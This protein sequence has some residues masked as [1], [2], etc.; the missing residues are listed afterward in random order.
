MHG[1]ISGNSLKI[2]VAFTW[3]FWHVKENWMNFPGLRYLNRD[4]YCCSCLILKQLQCQALFS[5][6]AL[7]FDMTI[8]SSILLMDLLIFRLIFKFSLLPFILIQKIIATLYDGFQWQN[9]EPSVK[10]IMWATLNTSNNC[11]AVTAILLLIR[12]NLLQFSDTI[13]L[14]SDIKETFMSGLK[15]FHTAFYMC[16]SLFLNCR[17]PR[18]FSNLA[19]YALHYNMCSQCG[20]NTGLNERWPPIYYVLFLKL[21][22]VSINWQ[23]QKNKNKNN[24][25]NNKITKSWSPR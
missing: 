22:Q 2:H 13:S 23:K 18:V 11:N 1:Q 25:K 3:E 7:N 14:V 10:V 17:A 9:T 8:F 6:Q 12:M 24:K 20:V 19:H 15:K 4:F 16:L 21:K 5:K